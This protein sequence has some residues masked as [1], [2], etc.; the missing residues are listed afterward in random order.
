M[1]QA[2]VKRLIWVSSVGVYNE[3]NAYELARVSP[4]LGGHKQSVNIIEQSD[5]NYTIIRPGWLSNEDSINYGITQKGEDFINPQ[6][7]ISRASVA[8]L[9]TKICLNNE[10]KPAINQV[11]YSPLYQ[12]EVLQKVMQEYNVKLVSWSSFGRGREG[13]LDNPVLM[14]IAKK[15]N[16]T[17]AQ[18]V[19]RWLTEQ[20]IIVMPKTTK[21]ERMIE[22]I[23]IF[24][25]KL[26]SN[27]KAQIAKL[28]KGKSLF[29]NPQDVER[30]KW[31]NSDEY[32]TMES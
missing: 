19:L 7:Y 4:W 28:N 24:D 5:I 8:D 31:L 15:H 22:N 16:K 10:I 29:F 3:V 9:I 27:D 17:I 2:G 30:I 11:E 12:R 25:F 18:V 20:D 23:S 26:D 21:K 6:K 32:N 13:V 14:K 1:Q